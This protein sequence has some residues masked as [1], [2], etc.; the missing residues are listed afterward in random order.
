[1]VVCSLPPFDLHA[2]WWTELI[3]SYTH[4]WIVFARALL[5]WLSC[6]SQYFSVLPPKL[7][8]FVDLYSEVV[9]F[10]GPQLANGLFG[11]PGPPDVMPVSLPA[12]ILFL[13]PLASAARA[14][15][16][17]RPSPSRRPPARRPSA[18]GTS[19]LAGRLLGRPRASDNRPG[20]SRGWSRSPARS[21]TAPSPIGRS[22]EALDG[23]DA[24][25]S[26]QR[27]CHVLPLTRGDLLDC[28]DGW[29][30][31]SN[32][33]RGYVSPCRVVLPQ[34]MATWAEFG[35]SVV[36]IFFEPA[37]L[38]VL[39]YWIWVFCWLMMYFWRCW[40]LCCWSL[41]LLCC[42]MY[43]NLWCALF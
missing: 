12:S 8:M 16:L 25:G 20:G 27:P 14:R 1:M 21:T 41:K 26:L 9:C 30:A 33:D 13:A 40:L 24:D 36:L 22:E 7:I 4:S 2:L 38:K 29:A 32:G 28:S 6:T 3:L 35:C 19:P 10:P 31:S 43:R 23:D 42:W 5:R 37:A 11:F 18:T 17:R 34:A 39:L 15:P